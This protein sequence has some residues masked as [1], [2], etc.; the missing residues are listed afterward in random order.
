MRVCSVSDMDSTGGFYIWNHSSTTVVNGQ[1]FQDW[2]INDYI[3][4]KAVGRSPLV[5][6]FFW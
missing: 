3:L 2:F 5:S 6:G 1:T 4:N